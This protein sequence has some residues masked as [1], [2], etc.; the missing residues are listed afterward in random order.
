MLLLAVPGLKAFKKAGW[1]LVFY[2]LL[3]NL[4]YG[5]IVAFTTYG[6]FGDLLGAAIG[7]LIGT[8]LLFQVRSHFSG[9]GAR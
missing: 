3:I 8:Y 5:V 7:S 2:A 1:N 6:T 9:K 4:A